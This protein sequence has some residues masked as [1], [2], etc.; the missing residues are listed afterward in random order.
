MRTGVEMAKVEDE[1]LFAEIEKYVTKLDKDAQ[2]FTKQI[3]IFSKSTKASA[4]AT[5]EMAKSFSGLSENTYPNTDLGAA[6]RLAAMMNNVAKGMLGISSTL[7][8]KN[9]AETNQVEAV[10]QDFANDVTSVKLALRRRK[11]KLYRLTTKL[12]R[13]TKVG[14]KLDRMK[15]ATVNADAIAIQAQEGTLVEAREEANAAQVEFEIVSG[16]VIREFDWYRNVVDLKL[17]RIVNCFCAVQKEYNAKLDEGWGRVL[18]S[19][20]VKVDAKVASC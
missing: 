4:D 3:S 1:E 5:Q 7:E 14:E 2:I 9:S 18:A 15:E 11:E 13:I 10:I 17:R 6:G 8:E 12:N 16:R 20:D 19:A